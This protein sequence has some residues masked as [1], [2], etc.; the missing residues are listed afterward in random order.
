[1]FIITGSLTRILHSRDVDEN[2]TESDLSE[3]FTHAESITAPHLSSQM[4]HVSACSALGHSLRMIKSIKICLLQCQEDESTSKETEAGAGP[5][6]FI[7][8]FYHK[9]LLASLWCWV[10]QR[11]RGN[12]LW[13]RIVVTDDHFMCWYNKWSIYGSCAA[14]PSQPD[15]ALYLSLPHHL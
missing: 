4:C 10:W 14:L 5:V 12:A 1:M 13:S 15:L 6:Y 11:D 2:K 7:T 9:H 8:L 3:S